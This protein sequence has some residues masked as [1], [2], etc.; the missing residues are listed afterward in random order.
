M[1]PQPHTALQLLL[2]LTQRPWTGC[3]GERP[4]LRRALLLLLLPRQQPGTECLGTHYLHSHPQ[5]HQALLLLLLMPREQPWI[6]C[7]DQ[8]PAPHP[9][10]LLLLLPTQRPGT[11]YVGQH[12]PRH[13]P[14]L[15]P[16]LALQGPAAAPSLPRLLFSPMLMPPLLLLL[17]PS[18]HRHAPVLPTWQLLWLMQRCQLPL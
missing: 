13:L 6:E 11:E 2:L 3:L 5:P 14:Q 1:D 8:H 18:F 17:V 15:T 10:L 16:W 12:S 7:L 9:A 4:Q